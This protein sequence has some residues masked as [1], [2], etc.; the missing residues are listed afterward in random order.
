WLGRSLRLPSLR[1]L[2][3]EV[4]QLEPDGYGLSI[5]PFWAG[6]RSPGWAH[7]ARGAI[8]GLRLHHEPIDIMRAALE[9]VALRFGE[10]DHLLLK[11]MPSG[12]EVVATG[13]ALLHSPA[14][15]Q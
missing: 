14:W 5:L 12:R 1:A 3:S 9:A 7:D 6:E 13:G 4:A 15:A 8:V 2:E 11:A 10:L